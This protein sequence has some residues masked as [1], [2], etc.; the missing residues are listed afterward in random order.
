MEENCLELFSYL[1]GIKDDLKM[2]LTLALQ[3]QV[4]LKKLV[5][6]EEE[7]NTRIYLGEA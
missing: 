1:L 5:V 3:K 2:N 4:R 7:K 6:L